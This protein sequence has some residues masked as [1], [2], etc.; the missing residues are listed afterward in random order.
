VPVLALALILLGAF[1]QR[2][3]GCAGQET[4]VTQ[5]YRRRAGLIIRQYDDALPGILD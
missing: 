3:P 5:A 1:R 2:Q 4:L